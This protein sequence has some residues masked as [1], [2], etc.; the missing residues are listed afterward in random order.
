MVYTPAHLPFLCV[1]P[2]GRV[3]NALQMTEPT[4]HGLRD[5]AAGATLE[6]FFRLEIAS[7]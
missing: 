3:N 2:V 5:P 1:E 7:A 4:A 6:A